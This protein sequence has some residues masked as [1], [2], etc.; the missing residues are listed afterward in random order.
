MSYSAL[1]ADQSIRLQASGREPVFIAI[2]PTQT[3][4]SWNVIDEVRPIL[5]RD[6]ASP[7]KPGLSGHKG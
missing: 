3:V 2:C 4:S 1:C 6:Q 5:L 7:K